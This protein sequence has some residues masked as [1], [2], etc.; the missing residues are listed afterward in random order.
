[1]ELHKTCLYGY[2]N[3]DGIMVISTKYVK[4]ILCNPGSLD[5]LKPLTHT[6]QNPSEPSRR[7]EHSSSP[8]PQSTQEWPRGDSVEIQVHQKATKW[9]GQAHSLKSTQARVLKFLTSCK[10]PVLE[11]Q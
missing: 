5:L 1:M 6:Y 10:F 7:L 4:S 8:L 3:L 9:R 2:G 11:T